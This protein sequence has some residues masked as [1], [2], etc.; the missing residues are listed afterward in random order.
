VVLAP[1]HSAIEFE[2][3]FV[4]EEIL[5]DLDDEGRQIDADNLVRELVYGGHPLGFTITGSLDQ[6]A[7]FDRSMLRRHHARHYTAENAVLS[8]AGAVDA[9]QCFR[10][11]RKYFSPMKPGIKVGAEPPPM[12]QKGPR[13]RHV[14]NISSQTTL[15]VAFRALSDRDS[16]E[17][18]LEMLL[19]VLDDGMSTRLYERI[20]D[21]K[22]LCYDVGALY[23]SYEDDGVF[24]VAAEV[25]HERVVKV[26]TEIVSVIR[27]LSDEGPTAV[28]LERAKARHR[29]QT[30]SMLDDADALASFYALSALSHLAATPGERHAELSAV[31]P[32]DVREAAAAVFRPERLSIVTVGS[33][34][35][36]ERDALAGV[37]K[38]LR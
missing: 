22:G 6:L 2:R 3:G 15:R 38:S 4:K 21:S 16:R 5:E 29:W 14:P 34:K 30:Q 11:A 32:R 20:C 7:R 37:V 8:F 10:L 27:E 13:I 36:S 1:R 26:A 35:Q 9:D 19:R 23:E 31:T 17:P 18:A 33:L 28:E 25:Q 24:D 12:K